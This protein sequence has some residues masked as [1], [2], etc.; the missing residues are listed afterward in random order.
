MNFPLF[1]VLASASA[2]I[3]LVLGWHHCR[4]V[5]RVTSLNIG[6]S[7]SNAIVGIAK[8]FAITPKA[9]GVPV[10]LP[11]FPTAL[12]GVVWGVSD[13]AIAAVNTT[14]ADGT[15]ADVTF[16]AAGTVT[17]TVTGKDK[18]GKELSES[19]SVVGEVPVPLVDSLNLAEV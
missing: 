4:G 6:A 15:T 9:G 17:V 10:D 16:S 13:P 7:M 19:V 18:D 2:A 3:L 12:T 8:A 14:K 11:V 1:V 5:P